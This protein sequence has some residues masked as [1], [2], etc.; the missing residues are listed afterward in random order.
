MGYERLAGIFQKHRHAGEKA[1]MPFLT[2][3]DPDL[4]LTRRLLLRMHDA[5]ASVCEIGVPFSDP[6]AD[7]PVIQASMTRAL[8]RRVRPSAV[9][10]MV[11]DVRD[12]TPIGLIAM[13]SFSIVY[14]MGVETFCLQAAEHGLDGLILP[15]LP[16]EEAEPTRAACERAGLGCA[17][18]IA[19]TTPLDRARRLAEA[20]RGF[21]YIVSRSGI[22]GER[23]RL[24][25]S[26]TERLA[27]LREV[28]RSPL[29][30]GFGIA[31]PEHVRAVCDVADAAIVGTALVR[32]IHAAAEA[33]EDPVDAGESF[34]RH[35]ATGLSPHA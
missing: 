16:I 9:L 35:L 7:G 8:A 15:D 19:P 32:T 23:N 12:R 24:P 33:G 17:F 28:T 3:G 14:R 26:L 29:A 34:V 11:G 10:E 20:S 4:D 6:I 27:S 22:T 13:L 2:A 18:L 21:V 30:V 25:A 31:T 5:G 1:L